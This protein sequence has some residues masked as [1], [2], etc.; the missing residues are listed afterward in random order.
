MCTLFSPCNADVPVGSIFRFRQM[1]QAAAIAFFFSLATLK[2]HEQGASSPWRAPVQAA[3]QR[4]S[5]TRNSPPC[6]FIY[7]YFFFQI[8]VSSNVV[9]TFPTSSFFTT[10]PDPWPIAKI[11]TCH[12]FFQ[13]RRRRRDDT[14]LAFVVTCLR[15]RLLLAVSSVHAFR[16]VS[17]VIVFYPADDGV[18]YKRGSRPGSLAWT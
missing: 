2:E 11:A 5:E 14:S 10:P 17:S 8:I 3:C 9:C 4:K 6:H 16:R 12:S 7:I 15:V 18:D 1:Q 13:R